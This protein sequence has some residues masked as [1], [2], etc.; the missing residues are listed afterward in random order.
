VGQPDDALRL[1]AE[2]VG[3]DPGILPMS[4]LNVV[5]T[6][7]TV[8]WKRQRAAI[9]DAFLPLQSLA[10]A[11]T[12]IEDSVTSL[13]N[14]WSQDYS[15]GGVVDIKVEMHHTALS[16]YLQILLGE[17]SAFGKPFS[18]TTPA[19]SKRA[20]DIFNLEFKNMENMNALMQDGGALPFPIGLLELSRLGSIEEGN[21]FN[22]ACSIFSFWPRFRAVY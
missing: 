5:N 9:M 8:A 7:D 19:E 4:N 6:P 22:N 14:R 18:E 20:R 2:H 15:S 21:K 10:P 11:V 13:V 12:S 16:L 3:K 1:G 17:N